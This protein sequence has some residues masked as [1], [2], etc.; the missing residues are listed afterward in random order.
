MEER[1]LAQ[2]VA[3]ASD[4]G[5]FNR[6]VGAPN[7]LKMAAIIAGLETAEYYSK[8][9]LMAQPFDSKFS[10]MEHA[11]KSATLDG[12]VLE[13]GVGGGESLRRL[14]A[15]VDHAVGFDS[16]EGLPEDWRWGWGKGSF[17][18]SELPALPS[19]VSLEIG[20]F[21]ESLPRYRAKA[22]SGP[23]RF[24]HVDCDLYSSART[25]FDTLGD[26]VTGGT[27]I[28]FDEYWNYPGWK[29]HEHKAFQEFI[30][31]TGKRY[32]YIGFVPNG[33]QV[34]VHIY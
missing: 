2:L 7:V 12:Q 8:R 16:F 24:I 4:V 9:A 30:E 11:V 19:N 31:R 33:V 26:W 3:A 18:Q 10:L 27:I 28:L 17:A 6:T 13:F 32:D 29:E 15:L 14:A 20:V 23:A 34:A 25:V 1:E 21:D 22:G 5:V